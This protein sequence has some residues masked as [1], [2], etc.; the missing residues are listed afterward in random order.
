VVQKVAQHFQLRVE[1]ICSVKRDK[2]VIV[3]RQIA[4]Y[5]LR[6]ELHESFPS[7]SKSLGRKDH[8]TAMHSVEKIT[9]SIKLDY[10]IREHV[11]D[12]REK[13]YV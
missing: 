1:D 2:Q 13:L 3:P 5:L 8:T 12:I 11:A 4:M 6:S 7:I 10:V 9:R